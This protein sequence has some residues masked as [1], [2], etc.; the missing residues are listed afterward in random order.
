M[1]E[2]FMSLFSIVLIKQESR[3]L[4]FNLLGGQSTYHAGLENMSLGTNLYL[5]IFVNRNCL[6]C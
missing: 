1:T 6:T 2:L 3:N 5:F 4:S